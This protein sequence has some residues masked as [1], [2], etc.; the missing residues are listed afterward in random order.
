[1]THPSPDE[2][3]ITV[4]DNRGREQIQR[5]EYIVTDI[6]GELVYVTANGLAYAQDSLTHKSQGYLIDEFKRIPKILAHPD[7][8]IDDHTSP[9][10]TQIYYKRVYVRTM[11]VHLLVAV[12]VKLRQGIKFLYNFHVQQS[13]KVKGYLAPVLPKV[14]Y[15]APGQKQRNFGL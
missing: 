10:D 7:I 9:D 12:V 4:I 3:Y 5:V 2:E 13:G 1:M 6:L 11:R 14:R 8:L 15:L